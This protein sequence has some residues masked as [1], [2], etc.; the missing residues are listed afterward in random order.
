MVA[1]G[2][3]GGR[4]FWVQVWVISFWVQVRVALFFWMQVLLLSCWEQMRIASFLGACVVGVFLCASVGR[5]L[6]GAFWVQVWIAPFWVQVWLPSF[7]G[8]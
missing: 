3:S 1:V 4:T 8:G 2:A 6:L 7:W 5:P